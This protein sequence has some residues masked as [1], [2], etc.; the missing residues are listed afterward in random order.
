MRTLIVA[1]MA[2]I[3]ALSLLASCTPPEP[4]PTSPSTSS[5]PTPIPWKSVW[6]HI[7]R[8]VDITEVYTSTTNQIERAER[9]RLW[10]VCDRGLRASEVYIVFDFQEAPKVWPTLSP[11][12][13]SRILENRTRAMTATAVRRVDSANTRA[14]NANDSL[15]K[16][17]ISRRD[18]LEAGRWLKVGLKHWSNKHGSFVLHE[19]PAAA[20]I[21]A[22]KDVE[23]L[24]VMT[25]HD[26]G[27]NTTAVFD[28]RYLRAAL[29]SWTVD[30]TC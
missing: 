9:A 17:F 15:D 26:Y 12:A 8:D 10:V 5:L 22:L 6:T 23:E 30:W 14:Q 2:P 16:V 4:D 20:F 7:E 25:T 13:D 21:D 28:V 1:I 27:G 3:V 24:A 19:V 11:D 29:D 18:R